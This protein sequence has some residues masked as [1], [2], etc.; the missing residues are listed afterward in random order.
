MR[1]AAEKPYFVPETMKAD[2]LFTNMKETRNHFAIV[3]DE[4]GGTRGVITMHDL[5]ELLVGDLGEKDDDY[6]VEIK[7]TDDSCWEIM[8]SAL[9]KDVEE[10]LDLELSEDD[11]DTFGGYIF[12]LLEAI[13]DDGTQLELETEDLVIRVESIEDHRVERTVVI[14]KK[15]DETDED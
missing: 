14:K 6:I 2:V 10:E 8:G 4:Y 11:Y 5:L 15:K 9:L 12:G 7:K 3:I 13:P 1:G